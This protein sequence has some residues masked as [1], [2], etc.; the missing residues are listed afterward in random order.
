MFPLVALVWPFLHHPQL[1]CSGMRLAA[2]MKDTHFQQR[3]ARA[4]SILG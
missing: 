4:V 1:G 3:R 2:E